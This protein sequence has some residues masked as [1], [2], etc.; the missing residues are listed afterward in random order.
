MVH[1]Q[2]AAIALG[3]VMAPVGLG[4]VAPLADTHAT[5]SLALD[6]GLHAHEGLIVGL[7]GACLLVRLSRLS[8]EGSFSRLQVFEILVN[9]LS[10]LFLTL[11]NQLIRKLFT[12]VAALFLL[13][14]VV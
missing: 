5:I 1:L 12:L 14:R 11:L 10:R 7:A 2:D 3:A 6:G 8:D 4:L 9:N 13:L